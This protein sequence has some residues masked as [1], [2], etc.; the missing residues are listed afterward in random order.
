VHIDIDLHAVESPDQRAAARAL[1]AE[2]LHWVAGV[3]RSSYG[4]SFDV[5]AMVRSNLDDGSK[6]FP[7]TGRFY[8]V[9]YEGAYAGVGCRKRL[10]PGILVAGYVAPRPAPSDAGRERVRESSANP[11]A[12]PPFD[13]SRVPGR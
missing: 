3:A 4:L 9:R 1:V 12:P 7:P 13:T 8:L 10:T 11:V 5:E 2:H 6:F